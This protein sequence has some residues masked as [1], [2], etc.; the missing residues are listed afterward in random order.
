M[1]MPQSPMPQSPMPQQP[2]PPA[3]PPAYAPGPTPVAVTAIDMPF[4][5]L[6]G[7]FF[8]ATL[9]AIPAV[10]VAVLLLKL[11]FSMLLFVTGGWR[12]GYWSWF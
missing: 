9:A 1:T 11:V 10:I 12:Y 4:T 2:L 3:P 7:F 6:M 5:R 8:K